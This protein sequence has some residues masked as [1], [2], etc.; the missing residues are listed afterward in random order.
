M[1]VD[2][3]LGDKYN[4]LIYDFFKNDGIDTKAVELTDTFSL[5]GLAMR[6]LGLRVGDILKIWLLHDMIVISEVEGYSHYLNKN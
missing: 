2:K 3:E 4:N 5:D 1:A 6:T